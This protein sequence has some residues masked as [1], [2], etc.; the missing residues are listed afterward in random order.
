MEDHRERESVSINQ[1]FQPPFP[2]SYCINANAQTAAESTCA[3]EHPKDEM[4]SQLSL[5]SVTFT[6][7]E[8][9][10]FFDIELAN[11]SK[12]SGEEV[13]A[14]SWETDD[15]NLNFLSLRGAM[16]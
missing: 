4:P 16:N 12:K 7:C 9:L 11:F 5:P 13:M 8:S 2:A 15:F 1:R 6:V 14:P 10:I 3:G